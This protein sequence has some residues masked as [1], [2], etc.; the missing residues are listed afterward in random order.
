MSNQ[1]NLIDDLMLEDRDDVIKPRKGNKVTRFKPEHLLNI[2]SD[3]DLF[4]D[5]FQ[6]ILQH[7]T[8]SCYFNSTDQ[9]IKHL[10]GKNVLFSLE[11]Q[12]ELES[13]ATTFKNGHIVITRISS[14]GLEPSQIPQP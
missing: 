9:V 14:I 11:T 5:T 7:N 6:L 10:K 4:A 13:I 2:N 8:K 3:Y 1:E 12:R